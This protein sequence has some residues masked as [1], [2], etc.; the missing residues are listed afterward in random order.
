MTKDITVTKR[1]G[2]RE[3][4][5]LEKMHKVVFYAC[6]GIAGV[7]ASEVEIKSHLQF[8]NGIQTL[9]VQETN[10]AAD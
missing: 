5:D 6:E 3:T 8:Y 9:D 10:C 1:D 4:L 2:S 7:S